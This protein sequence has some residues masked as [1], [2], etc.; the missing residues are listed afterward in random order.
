MNNNKPKPRIAHAAWCAPVLALVLA[1]PGAQAAAAQLKPDPA[2]SEITQVIT[3]SLQKYHLK[4]RTLDDELSVMI[5]ERFLKLLDP[6][7]LYL[8][9][10][11][12]SAFDKHR[13]RLDNYL[14]R[15]NLNPVYQFFAVYRERYRERLRHALALVEKGFDF[16]VD[17]Y[18]EFNRKEAA[19]ARTG[20]ELDEIWRKIVKNNFLSAKLD[21]SSDDEARQALVKRYQS[22]LRNHGQLN[23]DEVYQWFINSYIGTLDP[24]SNYLSPRRFEE[25]QIEM[26][27][28]LEGI[29]AALDYDNEYTRIQ[30]LLPG[31]PASLS[32]LLHPGDRITGVAQGGDPI[33][34]VVG[35]R[36][37]DVVRLI[38]GEKGST[39]RLQVLPEDE[40]PGGATTVVSLVRDKIKLENR[41]AS[42]KIIEVPGEDA[43]RR[44]GVITLPGFYNDFRAQRQGDE[45]FN[46]S[47]LDVK[48]LL[49]EMK[50][51]MV[52]GVI[53]DLRGNSGGHLSEAVV[54]AGLFLA[55]DPVVQVKYPGN[56]VQV[57]YD[58]D[59][60]VVWDGPLAMLVDRYSAS[61]SEILA[62]AIQDHRRGIVIG[63]PTFG[64]GTV[65]NLFSI[66]G[67]YRKDGSDLGQLK[68]T[69]AQFYRVNGQS[70]QHR[71]VVPDV[72]WPTVDTGLEYGERTLP[73]ALPQD[74]IG[75]LQ[76]QLD[77]D[78]GFEDSI[79]EAA[80]IH[81]QRLAT[82]P[83][84][85]YVQNQARGDQ[86]ARA[87]E[88]LSLNENTRRLEL[89]MDKQEREEA[90]A[91]YARALEAMTGAATGA[92]AESAELAA[93]PDAPD[94]DTDGTTPSRENG[95]IDIND[96]LLNEAALL[97]VHFNSVYASTEAPGLTKVQ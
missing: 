51:E 91:A 14:Q 90:R 57:E 80:L 70:T 2:H 68:I 94:A 15:V 84:L 58:D 23:T 36:L 11:D 28:S 72:I 62:S 42:K 92:L 88:R 74:R 24:H 13:E 43:G 46:S 71:G 87:R 77:P 47:S 31:G 69:F 85:L 81:Q 32:G 26:S 95:A 37:D 93:L 21:G 45:H 50:E 59:P 48:R 17:E 73:N 89:E 67:L 60:E 56:Y 18:Y 35:W 97:L 33:V 30:R 38:R 64:K 8:L 1:L 34:D 25:F 55:G 52:D 6:D 22:R 63:E 83:G 65:Q 9:E 61:A 66:D 96:I 20:A 79:H 10:Q 53:I 5:H 40:P 76:K 82:A 49:V 29:G 54:I 86:T 19:W 27:L 3:A 75:T 41:A 4:N 78:P 44:I 16:G 12:V 39:V 7:R